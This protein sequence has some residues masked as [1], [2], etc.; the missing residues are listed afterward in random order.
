MHKSMADIHAVYEVSNYDLNT[1]LVS[2]VTMETQVF[3]TCGSDY[4]HVTFTHMYWALNVC[5][6]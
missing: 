6:T 2:I 1:S 4:T 5:Y 3:Q